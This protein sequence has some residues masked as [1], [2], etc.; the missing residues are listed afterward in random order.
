MCCNAAM[1]NEPLTKEAALGFFGNNPKALADALGISRTAIYQWKDG[2]PIP[3]KQDLRL[4]YELL[5]QM[6]AGKAN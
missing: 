1:L 3:A 5:P 6:I 4:R 2:E